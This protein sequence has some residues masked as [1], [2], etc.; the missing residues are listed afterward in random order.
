MLIDKATAF[1]INDD[2]ETLWQPIEDLLQGSDNWSGVD[3]SAISPAD[4]AYCKAIQ[5]AL[6]LQPAAFRD[7]YGERE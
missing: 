4:A 1:K 7:V 3:F 2:G 5:A 6:L